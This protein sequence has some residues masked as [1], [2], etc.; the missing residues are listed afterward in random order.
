VINLW[1]EFKLMMRV[2]A[3]MRYFKLMVLV[4]LGVGV[5]H[6]AAMSQE[7]FTV[8][9]N[10]MEVIDN[11]TGLIWQ[12]C[13]VGQWFSD[14]GM[15][16]NASCD[17]AP[18]WMTLKGAFTYATNQGN[19]WRVPNVQELSGLMDREHYSQPAQDFVYFPNVPFAKFHTSTPSVD[20]PLLVW[21]VDA[22]FG[23][24]LLSG[25]TESDGG[26]L[27]LVRGQP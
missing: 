3:C 11:K 12:R 14:G 18:S 10:K 23:A 2:E 22:E 26:Y 19:G 16:G 7:R 21:M 6:G 20:N 5:F 24:V 4:L 17:G 27:R 1:V 8:A 25:R 9:P 15:S 13:T